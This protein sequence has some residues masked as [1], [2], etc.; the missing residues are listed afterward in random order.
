MSTPSGK[1]LNPIDPSASVSHET[2]ERA[3][4]ERHPVENDYDDLQSPYAPKK[5]RAQ[6]AVEQDFAISEDAVPL[7]PLRA[8]DGLRE[9]PEPRAVDVPKPHLFSHDAA[10]GPRAPGRPLFDE[11]DGRNH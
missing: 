7:A 2:H 9:H 11:Q 3:G 4:A 1:P 5:A 10:G 6:P 8:P